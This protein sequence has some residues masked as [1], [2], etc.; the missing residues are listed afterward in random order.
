MSSDRLPEPSGRTGAPVTRLAELLAEAGDTARPG[1]RE[2]AE[3]LWLAGRLG[4]APDADRPPEPAPPVPPDDAPRTTPPPHPAPPPPPEP[5][6]APPPHA[7]E[8]EPECGEDE[9]VPLH[10]PAPP[11][12]ADGPRHGGG[13]RTLHVPAPPMLARP[14]TLQRALRPLKRTVAAP[15]GHVL[16]ERATAHRIATLG[17]HPAWWLPVLRPA[18]ERWLRLDLVHDTGPTMPVWRPLVRELRD[19]LADSGIFRTVAVHRAGPD[20]RVQ[21]SGVPAPADGRTVTL[22]VSDCTGP[23]WRPGPAGTRWYAQLRRWAA[24]MPLAVVQPL[25]EHLWRTTALP[26]TPGLLTSPSPAAPN[27]SLDFESYDGDPRP[28]GALLPLPVLEPTADW[29]GHWAELVADPGGRQLPGAVGWLGARPAPAGRAGPV[30][31]VDLSATDLVLRFR[32][33]ASPE[34]FRL[35]GHLAVGRPELPVM[36]LVQAAIEPDPR[37]QHLAEVVLSGLLHTPDGSA[38]GAYAFRPGVRELL[39]NTLPR[40]AQ[41]RTEQLLARAGQLIEAR[42]GVA[43]PE[44][45][46]STPGGDEPA[47]PDGP[48]ATVA[49]ET[50]R[51]LGAPPASPLIGGRYRLGRVL[52]RGGVHWS[53]TDERTGEPVVVHRAAADVSGWPGA[54]PEH[55]NLARVLDVCTHRGDPYLVVEYVQ[56]PSLAAYRTHAREAQDMATGLIDAVRT[57]HEAGIVHGRLVAENILVAPDGTP[58]IG[59]FALRAGGRGSREEDLRTLGGILLDLA[60]TQRWDRD[61]ELPLG[62]RELLTDL[63]S[64]AGPG[65]PTRLPEPYRPLGPL[66]LTMWRARHAGTGQEVVVQ[67]FAGVAADDPDFA[68]RVR[69]LGALRHENLVRVLDSG[70]TDQGAFLVTERVTGVNLREFLKE[71]APEDRGLEQERFLRLARQLGSGVEALRGEGLEH[72]D[73][74]ASHVLI[75]EDDRL[76]LCGFGSGRG[77]DDDLRKLGE[78]VWELSTRVDLPEARRRELSVLVNRLMEYDGSA[79]PALSRLQLTA[80]RPPRLYRLFGPPRYQEDRRVT[81]V[82]VPGSAESAVFA[83]LALSRKEPVAFGEELREA[84]AF[85][86]DELGPDVAAADEGGQR[87]FL[88]FRDG[89][90]TDVLQVESLLKQ[91]LRAREARR[92]ADALRLL[93]DAH[94]LLDGEPLP[95]VPGDRAAEAR[96]RMRDLALK[97]RLTRAELLHATG[98][99]RR[100]ADDL[101][102]L[103]HAHP[104]HPDAVRLRMNA[105]RNLGRREEALATYE[106]YERQLG[107]P[108]EV[109]PAIRRLAREIEVIAER[110]EARLRVDLPGPPYDADTLATLGSVLRQ[111]LQENRPRPGRAVLHPT[112]DGYEVVVT[113]V[114]PHAYLFDW[115]VGHLGD[116]LDRVPR[117]VFL[118]ALLGLGPEGLDEVWERQ[119]RAPLALAVSPELYDRLVVRDR[120]ADARLFRPLASADGTGTLARYCT[121]Q[122]PELSPRLEQRTLSLPSRYPKRP[123]TADVEFSWTC[124]GPQLPDGQEAETLVDVFRDAASRITRQYAPEATA[125]ALHALRK[126]L[127]SPR[128]PRITAQHGILRLVNEPPVER[129]IRRGLA[130]RPFPDGIHPLTEATTVLVAF[131]GPLA[132]LYPD[133]RSAAQASRDLLAVVAEHRD[134]DGAL[135]GE[136]VVRHLRETGV[137]PLDVLRTYAGH[138]LGDDLR[139]RLDDIELRAVRSARRNPH[140]A[141]LLAELH[142]SRRGVA[143]VSDTSAAALRTWLRR[144]G[145]VPVG[146]GA[147]G[148]TARLDRLMPD[149]DCLRRA[150]DALDNPLRTATVIGASVAEF[151]AAQELGLHF[152]AYA[153]GARERRGFREAGCEVVVES[154]EALLGFTDRS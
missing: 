53:A 76:V 147:H 101:L 143:I 118:R 110:T 24:R 82:G 75:T 142:R 10:L 36:R 152:V 87:L 13:H 79:L 99:F 129:K 102:D 74:L 89:D 124:T 55:P 149:P 111:S 93:D 22:V 44:F 64:G 130:L 94:A 68:D 98:N 7:P 151:E 116:V 47:P 61:V 123:F 117:S 106:A 18:P 40:S 88:R 86:W 30:S 83:E 81:T 65:W 9:R 103:L 20:G 136:P 28:D 26:T 141:A 139:R 100:A 72:G 122:A 6:P 39:L 63:Q 16:D 137:H 52:G 19:A 90:T 97:L 1:P 105:L 43:A 2:L 145:D 131:D 33:Q 92:P 60:Y 120:L 127:R 11:S 69:R 62:F 25:P 48:I 4:G 42:A 14:L 96:A 5:D 115:A 51:R 109:D 154:M 150:L 146:G 78:H 85:V 77:P 113:A 107:S 95:D 135:A 121:W 37:P 67:H 31:P 84:V 46:A 50:V 17:G 35:A 128:S 27:A 80:A 104:G 23:Q 108:R 148:R 140:G 57:L 59:G 144:N 125:T 119:V 3:L 12:G 138:P 73:L 15:S 8:P 49:P 32:S 58:K 112:A 66:G 132:H 45:T 41:G 133:E 54:F 21:H 29:L 56:G 70:P 71:F 126:G 34:A 153:R 91:A 134:V 114:E 38:P